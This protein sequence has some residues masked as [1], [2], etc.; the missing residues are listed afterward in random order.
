M[1]HQGVNQLFSY[2]HGYHAGN[3]ADVLKHICQMLI[4]D[5]LKQK[6]KASPISIRTVVRAYM[7]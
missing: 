7:I 5:K 3:H 4:I 1:C 6:T 2:R